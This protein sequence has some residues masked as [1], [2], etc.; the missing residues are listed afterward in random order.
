MQTTSYHL[1][2]YGLAVAGRQLDPKE[3]QLIK[4]AY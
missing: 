1:D 2:D 3:A 4:L